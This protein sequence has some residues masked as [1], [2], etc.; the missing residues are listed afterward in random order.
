[1]VGIGAANLFA[2]IFSGFPVSTSGS[3]TAVAEP[4][5]AKTQL[6]GIVAGAL[7]LAM[8]Q[9]FERS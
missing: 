6:A 5:S 8:L 1:M 2:G 9:F 7:V 3:R 4:S